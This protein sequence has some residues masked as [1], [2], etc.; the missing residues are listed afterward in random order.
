M[1]V[2]KIK[3]RAEVFE[4][5]SNV[6]SGKIEPYDTNSKEYQL[7]T[8]STY[9]T[10]INSEIKEIANSIIGDEKNPYL[11]AKMIFDYV[12]KHLSFNDNIR[13]ER[14]SSVESLLNYAITDPETGEKHFE[15]QCD[16]YSI[17]FVALCR[18]VGIPARGVT[19]MI[20]G[21]PWIKKE[22]LK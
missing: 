2:V 10:N 3:S 11:K 12:V 17:L 6:D 5:Y 18:A 13:R 14:G 15:G 9:T 19:G 1:Y 21:G 20:G 8:R 22:D 7:Y 4:V 16:H